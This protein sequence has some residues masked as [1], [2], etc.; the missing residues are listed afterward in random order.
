ML[1]VTQD[2]K[3]LLITYFGGDSQHMA[4]RVHSVVE[5]DAATNFI[6]SGYNSQYV[7][8]V[9]SVPG[10]N[11]GKRAFV[12]TYPDGPY[13]YVDNKDKS[14]NY[15]IE[16]K[17]STGASFAV[18]T[19]SIGIVTPRFEAVPSAKRKFD[20]KPN[21]YVSL[22][23]VAS[24]DGPVMDVIVTGPGSENIAITKRNN[25]HKGIVTGEGRVPDKVM[26]RRD[27]IGYLYTNSH[28]KFMG[29]AA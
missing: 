15:T 10:D 7:V 23:Q 26:V 4:R 6:E 28:I 3:K 18:E 1:G 17:T 22:D 19:V 29:D 20:I 14:S 2:K 11:T 5:V 27:I 8:T 21:S 9:A 13:F 16:L 24:I 25:K 12:L